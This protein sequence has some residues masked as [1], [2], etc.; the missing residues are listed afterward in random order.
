MKASP[1][2]PKLLLSKELQ[3]QVELA[4]K[5]AGNREWSG[6]LF[7][8]VVKPSD[9]PGELQLKAEM[10]FPMDIGSEAFTT[11]DAN[12]ELLEI[13]RKYPEAMN[14]QT[15][16]IH[17]HHTMNA[18]FSGTDD[19]T[20]I[21]NAKFYP[22]YLSLIMSMASAPVA[23]VAVQWTVHTKGTETV[24]KGT[25]KQVKEFDEK[26]DQVFYWDC[27]ILRETPR[28]MEWFAER[29]EGLVKKA[30]EA[31]RK[32]FALGPPRK[33]TIDLIEDDLYPIKDPLDLFNEH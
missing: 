19:G 5:R 30:G 18:F 33:N 2:K 31:P 17:T 20:L 7:F 6:V 9:N 12:H 27:E 10:F 22:F 4:H 11:F 15:G 23:R 26:V 21:E 24:I 16:L 8:T 13:Y 14:M 28:P 1:E 32:P 3:L 29:L 25:E